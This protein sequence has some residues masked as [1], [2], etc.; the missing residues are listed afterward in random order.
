MLGEEEKLLLLRGNGDRDVPLS[1][2]CWGGTQRGFV[3]IWD[4]LIGP[5]LE[6]PNICKLKFWFKSKF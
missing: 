4:S 1:P 3:A 2:D 6:L 5:N